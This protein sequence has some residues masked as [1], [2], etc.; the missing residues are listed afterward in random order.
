MVLKEERIY[1]PEGALRVEVIQR[2]YN[3]AVEGH[4]GRWKTTELVG[5]NY[6]W[7]GMTKW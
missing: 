2:H 3:T 5:R 4:R 7:P 1:M 6:W